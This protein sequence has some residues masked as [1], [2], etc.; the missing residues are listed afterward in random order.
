M[1]LS[2]TVASAAVQ[3][4]TVNAAADDNPVL[5]FGPRQ[6]P[7]LGGN[8]WVL[9]TAAIAALGTPVASTTVNIDWTAG[10]Y[11]SLTFPTSGTNVIQFATT[12]TGALA[13]AAQMA[14]F[15]LG[16]MIIIQCAW[17]CRWRHESHLA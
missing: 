11:F 2:N 17:Q 10:G 15:S 4:V 5:G 13:A 8:P 9:S 6:R 12:A 1:I 16:Q 7:Q 3:G 14:S